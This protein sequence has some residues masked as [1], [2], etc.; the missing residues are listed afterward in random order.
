MSVAGIANNLCHYTLASMSPTSSSSSSN[1]FQQDFQK[2]GQDLQAG[3][4]TA[5][6]ADLTALQ[7]LQSSTST[8]SSSANTSNSVTQMLQQLGTD[9]QSGDLKDAQQ[10]FSSMSQRFQ[11]HHGHHMHGGDGAMSQEMNQL[12][13]D[14]QSGNL[15]AAQQA[16][17]TLQQ[18][19]GQ[20]LASGVSTTASTAADGVSL[21]V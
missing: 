10:V 20:F 1:P 21:Q 17:S 16:Y 2:L 4:L 15:T 18:D 9:L 5:A 3:N 13:Q 6:Q 8:T 19:L 7:S 14:L 11:A 12:G